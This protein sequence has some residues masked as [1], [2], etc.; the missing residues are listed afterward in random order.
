MKDIKTVFTTSI[1]PKKAVFFILYDLKKII[2]NST[3]IK[4]QNFKIRQIISY[5][6]VK[7]MKNLILVTETKQKYLQLIHIDIENNFLVK[8]DIVSVILRNCIKN[9]GEISSHMPELLFANF[10]GIID[11]ALSVM[12]K[13][14]FDGLPDFKGRQLLSLYKKKKLFI[15]SISSVYFFNN[16]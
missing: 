14:L 15:Y 10:K 4:R 7:N 16:W 6:R 12:I 8:Y 11:Q 1:K 13:K 2:P 9:C 3:Y 5:L